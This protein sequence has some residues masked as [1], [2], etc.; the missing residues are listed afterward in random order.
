MTMITCTFEDGG[1][2]ALRHVVMD[3]IIEKDGKI[4]L[5]RRAS[6]LTEG[7][8][9]ALPG[10]FLNREET[11]EQGVLREL[12]EET[13]WEGKIVSLFQVNTS[14]KR[15]NE[16]RQNVV[17]VF[18]IEPIKEV[19]K[20]DAE[21]SEVVWMALDDLPPIES[22]AFDHGDML[23]LYKKYKEEQFSLPVVS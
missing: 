1:V 14:P 18:L 4:L 11:A 8:K 13:G 23:A 10:G 16:D 15:R 22:F 5:V 9:L 3:A 12:Q 6:H 17:F 21:A 2:A 19:G 20:P 7:G